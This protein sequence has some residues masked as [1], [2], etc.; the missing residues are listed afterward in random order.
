MKFYDFVK[1]LYS[2]PDR[3]NNLPE[4]NLNS[5]YANNTFQH[6]LDALFG[7]DGSTALTITEN[8]VLSYA[9]RA[10]MLEI[11]IFAT[12]DDCYKFLDI[13]YSAVNEKQLPGFYLALLIA[14][15][16]INDLCNDTLTR[17]DEACFSCGN[18]RHLTTLLLT[19]P[20][21]GNVIP[22]AKDVAEA[23]RFLI[24]VHVL[25]M[26]EMQGVATNADIFK[27]EQQELALKLDKLKPNPAWRLLN[28]ETIPSQLRSAADKQLLKDYSIFMTSLQLKISL[29]SI[30]SLTNMSQE[31]DPAIILA[32]IQSECCKKEVEQLAANELEVIRADNTRYSIELAAKV[33]K[34]EES[35]RPRCVLM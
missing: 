25:K 16:K 10:F 33:N 13:I 22:V 18:P 11:A 27:V 6:I 30:V 32:A 17:C 24:K 28:Q 9:A 34:I 14:M 8:E 23:L 20:N 1:F 15:K 2:K 21:D 26:R 4:T 35:K 29:Y 5:L 12:H 31:D 7:P 19:R 3:L